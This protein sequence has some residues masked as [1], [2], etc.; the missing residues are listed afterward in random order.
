MES[1]SAW[2]RALGSAKHAGVNAARICGKSVP[3]ECPRERESVPREYLDTLTSADVP[4]HICAPISPLH[5]HTVTPAHSPS[6][7]LFLHTVEAAR[8]N[9]ST[10]PH[11]HISAHLYHICTSTLSLLHICLSS[12]FCISFL[13]PLCI[14]IFARSHPQIYLSTSI[15]LHIYIAPAHPH[16]HSFTSTLSFSLS[17]YLFDSAGQSHVSLSGQ[18][19]S[20]FL[21]QFVFLLIPRPQV[22]MCFLKRGLKGQVDGTISSLVNWPSGTVVSCH[23]LYDQK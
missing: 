12:F 8:S 18:P 15:H 3:Q 22:S 13:S 5:I 19:S 11:P 9:L 14:Y 7:S 20:S 4:P 6:P 23:F 1:A 17:I 10:S 2:R 21:I 16:C